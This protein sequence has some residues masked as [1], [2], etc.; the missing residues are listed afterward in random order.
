MRR[1][2]SYGPID[3]DEHY[4][5]PRKAL[6]EKGMSQ[7]LGDN[8][9]KGGHYITVWAPRQTGKTWVMQET[10]R[11]L[12]HTG[13]FE[14]GM[15]SLEAVKKE[16]N[17][18]VVVNTFVSK[19]GEVFQ[20]KFPFVERISD[21]ATL[22]TKEYFQKP[23]ILILDEF[24]SLEEDF[25]NGFVSIFR[26]IF[27][28][29]IRQKDKAS[30]DKT[31]LLHGLGLVGVRSVLGIQN[32]KG[33]PFNVQRNLHIPNLNYGEVAEIFKWYEKESGQKVEQEVVDKLFYETGG[34]PGLTCWFGELLADGTEDYLI[35]KDR[36]VNMRDFEILYA[37]ATYALPNN[38]ILNII[39]KAKEEA[40][41][42]RVL[43]MFQTDEKLEFRF[44]DEVTNA[45]YMNGIADKE[46]V[47]RTRY[48]LRFSSPFVQ[49]RLFNH[50]SYL[51]FKEMGTLVEPFVCLDNVINSEGLNI[52]NLIALYGDYLERNRSWLFK[53]V[54]RRSDSKIYEAI[55]HFNLFT[56]ID[57]F[58]KNKDGRV[59]P[60]FP[61]G[62]GKID[63]IVH[64]SGKTYGLEL[65]SYTDQAGYKKALEQSAR[66]GKQLKL[67]EIYLLV[68]V[69]AIDD[70]NRK[71]YET[72]YLDKESGITVIPVFIET[73]N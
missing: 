1:F 16:K 68:F 7:L 20:R 58:L 5:A 57:R 36:P 44:D 45:L 38:N 12:E 15:L 66:Y 56:Y 41:K 31:N 61:T 24:D 11:K 55:F 22:F 52:K 28:G 8:P 14:T 39:S 70:K 71:K 30:N 54:P 53:N 26:D 17:E 9:K 63:W 13:E 37:A 27:T 73:G 18:K 33:S 35:P 59:I 34:Q 69:P 64:Y 48:Y 46:V 32:V 50:F 43:K 60:E 25:I 29:R 40:N 6:I 49:K 2:S 4:Y 3:T 72:N 19:L 47:E 51:Y 62:N 67:R 65:K 21:I 10:L 42:E 23:V